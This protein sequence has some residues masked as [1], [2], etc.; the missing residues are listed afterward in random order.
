V[1]A[2]QSSVVAV[3]EVPHSVVEE[4]PFKELAKAEAARRLAINTTT[5]EVDEGAED[6]A[7]VGK[8]MISRSETVI[9]QSTF[10]L[11]GR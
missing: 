6:V 5:T 2:A 9:L 8:T 7:L 11:T 1:V 4:A 10:V 3:N